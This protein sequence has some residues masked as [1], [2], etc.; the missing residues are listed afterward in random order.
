MYDFGL[1]L[2]QL[3]EGRRLSQKALAEKLSLS[4]GIISK[5]EANVKRPSLETMVNI[6]Y[7]FN[8]SLDYL[9]GIDK[10]EAVVVE[11][12]TAEQKQLIKKAVEELGDPHAN[13][14]VDGLTGRQQEIITGFMNEF[15][16]KKQ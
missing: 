2:K 7:I 6:A 14:Y 16:K 9:L 5:Y 12:L 8:C 1:L 4:T 3:R 10:K 15:A 13:P 11:H